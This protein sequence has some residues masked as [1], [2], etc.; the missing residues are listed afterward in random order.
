MSIGKIVG[1]ESQSFLKPRNR[2][3]DNF[4]NRNKKIVFQTFEEAQSKILESGISISFAASDLDKMEMNLQNMLHGDVMKVSL[5]QNSIADIKDI[6]S[7]EEYDSVFNIGSSSNDK[8]LDDSISEQHEEFENFDGLISDSDEFVEKLDDESSSEDIESVADS[9]VSE[10]VKDGEGNSEKIVDDP[11]KGVEEFADEFSDFGITF[12][13]DDSFIEDIKV[14]SDSRFLET[15][16]S[17]S[18]KTTQV[19]T[20][21]RVSSNLNSIEDPFQHTNL[22]FGLTNFSDYEI[23]QIK[24]AVSIDQSHSAKSEQITDDSDLAASWMKNEWFKKADCKHLRMVLKE[25]S[26]FD[27]MLFLSFMEE[28]K[29]TEDLITLIAYGIY[30]NR[31]LN[32]AVDGLKEVCNFMMYSVFCERMILKGV[33]REF[34]YKVLYLNM[35]H[36]NDRKRFYANISREYESYIILH[37]IKCKANKKEL[38]ILDYLFACVN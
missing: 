6:L 5:H 23:S 22:I 10:V 3:A 35:R 32:C 25:L 7:V 4:R 16:E 19:S 9:K 17:F 27:R 13:S 26:E 38:A 14:S 2:I 20:N 24:D 18:S 31:K 11:I 36:I 34:A 12:E 30:M 33:S 21:K 15:N 8:V 1:Q 37:P 28:D 29:V